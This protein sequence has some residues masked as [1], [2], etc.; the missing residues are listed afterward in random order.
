[1]PDR[2]AL[3]EELRQLDE[4]R[5]VVERRLQAVL[6]RQRYVSDPTSLASAQAEERQALMELD[7]VMTRSRAV[8]GK[9]L[10]LSGNS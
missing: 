3:E 8:E 2:A 1:M 4:R 10:Q 5:E 7:R 9:L 6:H